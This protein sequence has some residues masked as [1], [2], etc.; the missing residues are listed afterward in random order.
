[1]DLNTIL[2]WLACV[3]CGGILVSSLGGLRRGIR[4]RRA[5]WRDM[6]VS[7]WGLI[8]LA[9]LAAT[10]VCRWLWPDVAGFVGGGLWVALVVVPRAAQW[11]VGLLAG[12]LRFRRARR[13]A[14]WARWLYPWEGWFAQPAL[15]EALA[16]ADEGDVDAASEALRRLQASPWLG[17]SATV[18]RFRIRQAWTELIG[19]VRYVLGEEAAET[20]RA[21]LPLYLRALGEVGALAGLVAIFDRAR[22][23]NG[24]LLPGRSLC[25]LALFAFCGQPRSA[26]RVL[27]GPLSDVPDAVRQF[28]LATA[29]MAAGRPELGEARLRAVLPDARPGRRLAIEYRLAH[30][31]VPAGP[32]LTSLGPLPQEILHAT[33][34]EQE[35]ESR[36]GEAPHLSASELIVTWVLI[37]LNVAAFLVELARKASTDDEGLLRLGALFEPY[38]RAGQWWRL[39]T[40]NFLHFGWLHLLMNMLGLYVLGPFVEQSLG[41]V[42]YLLLYLLSGLASMSAVLELQRRGWVAPGPLVGAS[43]AIMGLVGA[44]AAVLLRGWFRERARSASRRLRWVLM[45]V[46]LQVVFDAFTPEVSST[47]HVTGMFWGFLLALLLFR[48]PILAARGFAPAFLDA[49]RS[50]NG[51]PD[52]VPRVLP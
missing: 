3:S 40:A 48:P 6:R 46:A 50:G 34:R 35:Q 13:L 42:R 44:T 2:L 30:P 29:E 43:G 24:G 19:W 49:P 26:Q 36:Y 37:G 16:L 27:D 23:R 52:R 4:W 21:V 25:R 17:L 15:L 22:W 47:A 20:D 39:L 33:E 32:V 45:I 11:R 28:W 18:H 9:I 5:R 12:R 1:M 31:P 10:G 41:R 38:V 7:G 51:Q 14:L 8:S